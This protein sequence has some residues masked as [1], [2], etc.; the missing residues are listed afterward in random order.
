MGIRSVLG[1]DPVDVAKKAITDVQEKL[2]REEA[3]KRVAL[4]QDDCASQLEDRIAATFIAPEVRQRIRPFV[5]LACATSVFRR[6]VD[7]VA[8]HVYNPAPG[9][10]VD[11]PEGAIA[12][13][14]IATAMRLD[15]RLDQAARLLEATN[16]VALM[17]RYTPRLGP[18]LDIITPDMMRVIPDPEDPTRELA[19]LV[20]VY[21]HGEKPRVECWD[22]EAVMLFDVD[23]KFL[24]ER[25]N[26][27]GTLPF[28]VVHKRERWG[29]Y[30]DRTSGADLVAAQGAV[31]LMT[32]LVLKLHKSQGEKQIVVQ[33]D[34]AMTI[35]G[36]TLDGEGALVT[37]EGVTITSLDL[38]SDAE[39]Y[40]RTIDNLIMRVS[41]NYGIS[42]ERMAANGT[43]L[44]SSSTSDAA[45]YERRAELLQTW[46]GAEQRLFNTFKV[47]FAGVPGMVI[48]E[49][50]SLRVDFR[51][52]EARVDMGTQL[53]LWERQLRL[54][55]K[56][57]EEMVMSMNREITSADE[58][59]ARVMSNLESW[60][61]WIEVRRALNA[62]NEGDPGQSPED[63]GRRG[64][65]VR[66]GVDQMAEDGTGN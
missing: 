40:N 48:P 51:E 10:E 63:N 44:T 25:P 41:A 23:G 15:Q 29:T 19:V 45:L 38:R 16:C 12:Y 42:K 7:E 35:Q 22:D 64:P 11:S 34:T 17:P 52:I 31:S 57:V 66:D 4:Y 14:T 55:L 56:S 8:R 1:L 54:G 36:Q 24:S 60:A 9:R 46:A 43:A 28:V 5:D 65:A 47:V 37:P 18:V 61:R 30:W 49:S 62:T 39:H 2:R 26:P 32:A 13:A 33:G 3:A 59:N 6:V 50:A 21:A 20:D 53:E 58:A 27:Y